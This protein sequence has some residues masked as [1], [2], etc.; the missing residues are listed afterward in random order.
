MGI[1]KTEALVLNKTPYS[2]TSLILAALTPEEGVM[3]FIGKGYRKPPRRSWS[4]REPIETFTEMEFTFYRSSGELHHLREA[5]VIEP[6]EGLRSDHRRFTAA[7]FAGGLAID[8]CGEG[9]SEYY[10]NLRSCWA[11][12]SGGGR[13]CTAV[14]RFWLRLLRLGGLLPSLERCTRCGVSLDGRTVRFVA[15]SGFLCPACTAS[16]GAAVKLNAGDLKYASFLLERPDALHRLAVP[17]VSLK[18]LHAVLVVQTVRELG[19]KPRLLDRMAKI[20]EN[21]GWK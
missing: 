21:T 1:A 4:P 7:A 14:L 8:F 9:G 11:E 16:S 17:P 2:N 10:E 13:P 5:A 3:S 15:G 18:R 6:F 12:L 19:R 20:W